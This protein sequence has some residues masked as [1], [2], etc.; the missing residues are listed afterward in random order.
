MLLQAHFFNACSL[1]LRPAPKCPGVFLLQEELSHTA[2]FPLGSW[3]QPPRVRL[4]WGE[5]DVP[6]IAYFPLASDAHKINEKVVVFK[7]SI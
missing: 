1:Y 2:K 7:T 4:V 5:P 6:A 3:Y